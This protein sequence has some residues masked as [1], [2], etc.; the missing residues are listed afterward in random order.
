MTRR[1]FIQATTVA[2]GA[3]AF[4]F[5]S[6]LAQATPI[7]RAK[8]TRYNVTS[9]EG[10]RA[11][12]SYAKGVQ[13]ML[14]LPADHPQNWFRNA[15]VH[16][17]DCPHGNWWF[18]V[19][20]RGYIGF[21]EETIRNLSGD[22]DFALPY[23]DWT[24]LPQIPD[25]MFDGPLNPR[26]M[27]F[28]RYTGNLS[29]FTNFIQ[30]PLQTYWNGLTAAQLA[31]LN[32][33]G[34]PTFDDFWYSV[35]G[36]DPASQNAFAGNIAY[37]TTCAARYLTRANPKFDAATAYDVSRHVVR[38]GI[39]PKD[40]YNANIALSFTSSKTPSHNT[41]PSASTNFSILEGMPHNQVHNYIGGVGPLDP[42]PYGNMTN[43]LSPVDP[44]FFLHHANMDR[45]W[46][47]WTRKQKRLGLPYLPSGADLKT[48]AEE[49]FLFFV[50]GKGDYVGTSHAGD[51]FSTDRFDYQYA[52]ST[53]DQTSGGYAAPAA[54]QT[55]MAVKAEMKGNVATLSIPR[56]AVMAHLAGDEPS[57]IAEV[58]I[59][60]PSPTSLTRSFDVMIGAPAS[61]TE[62]DPS[63]PF[64]AG[65][66][67]FFGSMRHAIGGGHDM[68][69]PEEATFAVPLPMQ[70]AAFQNLDAA[71][72]AISVRVVPAHK[73]GKAT[74]V[75]SVTVRSVQ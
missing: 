35:N 18:Y 37:A 5:E 32:V 48:L 2:V 43:F 3:A 51:Y 72:V 62:A 9:P 59:Q 64:F 61:M 10:Q 33:R 19:W 4:P 75:K 23:W 17:M 39:K 40:F 56:E 34:Y 66:I 53:D 49:P 16:L 42:G 20:H 28:E 69:M 15:F 38:S 57:L 27:P 26:N 31:Q 46:D 25:P 70:R 74:P 73:L 41:Q 30:A 22:M 1:K 8:Y 6:L 44:I 13:A 54:K 60:R 71:N 55:A 65:R 12:A 47:V 14:N 67:A 24:E 7:S 58:R 50:N 21:L 63:S 52:P 45:L 29:D 11:L 68:E 36:Y